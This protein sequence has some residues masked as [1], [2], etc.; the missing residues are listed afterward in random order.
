MS[1]NFFV[2]I[3]KHDSYTRCIVSGWVAVASYKTLQDALDT[4]LDDK[5]KE[6]K[7]FV[8][9]LSRVIAVNSICI[10]VI[11][12]R[13]DKIN[14]SLWDFAIISPGGENGEIFT[15]TGITLIFPVYPSFLA[16]VADKKL[17]D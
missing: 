2:K 1:D 4:V 16:F 8:F 17:K 11:Y 5:I 7:F 3:E 6:R 13:R 9:D 15:I 10:N 14:D 12:S